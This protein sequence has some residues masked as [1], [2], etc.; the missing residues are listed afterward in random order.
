MSTR[1]ERPVLRPRQRV[2]HRGM[3]PE[4]PDARVWRITQP[5][6]VWVT[7]GDGRRVCWHPDDVMPAP[8]PPR[9]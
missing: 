8:C 6:N 2:R 9:A 1:G 3:L 7:L 5:G 4:E